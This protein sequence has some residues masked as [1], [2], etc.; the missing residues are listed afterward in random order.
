MDDLAGYPHSLNVWNLH[1]CPFR[2]CLLSIHTGNNVSSVSMTFLLVNLHDEPTKC[3]SIP[4]N[5][6]IDF[7]GVYTHI[8]IYIYLYLS[9]Y[10]YVYINHMYPAS[11]QLYSYWPDMISPLLLM[12][13]P[14]FC[15]IPV[16]TLQP[17]IGT[18]NYHHL[19]RFETHNIP[20]S[21]INP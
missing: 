2:S 4:S 7:K 15:F 1:R 13:N 21:T 5:A 17:F 3:W 11:N 10:I 8:S 18:M 20:Q 14:L 6:G 19:S 12:S 16:A 9:L